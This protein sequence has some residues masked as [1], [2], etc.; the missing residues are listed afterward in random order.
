MEGVPQEAQDGSGDL[1]LPFQKALPYF[2]SYGYQAV[3]DF[4]HN[5]TPEVKKNIVEL[6]ANLD[7]ENVRLVLL[8]CVCMLLLLL[9][10]CS[11]SC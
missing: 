5:V 11:C 8:L 2:P 3:F 4:D 1:Y 7:G 9:F 6:I 10:C